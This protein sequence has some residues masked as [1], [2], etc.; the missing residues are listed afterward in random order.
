MF[1][2]VNGVTNTG[3]L[4]PLNFFLG[5][6]GGE[7]GKGKGAQKAAAPTPS[8]FSS[9]AAHVVAKVNVFILQQFNIKLRRRRVGNSS[10]RKQCKALKCEKSCGLSPL[11]S[12]QA[13][14][15]WAK[16]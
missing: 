14:A 1:F 16:K 3:T 6:T 15:S 7:S 13:A 11:Y 5:P 8:C 9:G 2:R 4:S 10:N 12:P